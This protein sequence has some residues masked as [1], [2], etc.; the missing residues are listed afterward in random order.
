[1]GGLGDGGGEGRR[2]NRWGGKT[3]INCR[4]HKKHIN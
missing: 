3:H 1:M 2:G 4:T